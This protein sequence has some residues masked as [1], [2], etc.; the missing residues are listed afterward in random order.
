MFFWYR[1]T[2]GRF[3]PF[4]GWTSRGIV[5]AGNPPWRVPAEAYVSLD[6]AGRLRRFYVIPRTRV[7]S[8]DEAPEPGEG[9]DWPMLF[10]LAGLN[11]ASF[12]PAKPR[13]TFAF[14]VD[15][16][17]AWSGVYPEAP[18]MAIQVEAGLIDG[19][20]SYFRFVNPWG[21]PK[22]AAANAAEQPSSLMRLAWFVE[23]WRSTASWVIILSIACG[24]GFV[25]PR[26]HHLTKGD[27]LG[28]LPIALFAY[29]A[30]LLATL[31]NGERL[32]PRGENELMS[33]LATATFMAGGVWICYVAL[34][35]YAR[36]LW[37]TM[38]IAWTR[39]LSG[40]MRDPLVG[41]SILVGTACGSVVALLRAL[42][43]NT[44]GWL[45]DPLLP[46]WFNFHLT[47]AVHH[48]LSSPKTSV[49]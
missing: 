20:P 27:L 48:S 4:S 41:K 40:R 32:L 13:F 25:V 38:L 8:P 26:R 36:R 31:L 39:L 10:D 16:R 7:S 19:K 30:M 47:G 44:P 15:E 3:R 34:E 18:D 45:G 2:P 29:V 28:A 17:I 22:P 35:P 12:T 9:A 11:F 37:P 14:R 1:Q 42:A 5:R 23:R 43:H 21:E 6:L 33:A 24:A 49:L 46:A